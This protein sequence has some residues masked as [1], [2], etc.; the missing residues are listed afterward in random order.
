FHYFEHPE[1]Y[2]TKEIS[3]ESAKHETQE[4]VEDKSKNHQQ[5]PLRVPD[6]EL[7]EVIYDYQELLEWVVALEKE[8]NADKAF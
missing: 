1:D 7:E 2:F 8:S 3:D 4:T 5:P 6:N